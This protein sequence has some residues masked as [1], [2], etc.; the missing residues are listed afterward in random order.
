MIEGT[1]ALLYISDESD[2]SWSLDDYSS[3][4]PFVFAFANILVPPP[5][6]LVAQDPFEDMMVETGKVPEAVVVAQDSSSL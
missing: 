2:P 4:S 6:A 5:D 3:S 1:S